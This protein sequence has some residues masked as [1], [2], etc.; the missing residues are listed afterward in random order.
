MRGET[1][2]LLGLREYFLGRLQEKLPDIIVNG[3]LENRLPNNL[4]I[5]FPGV[6]GGSLLLSLN[7]IGVYASSGS[8]CSAG[9]PDSSHVLK[10]I[11]VDTDHY[12]VIR[13]SMGL[14]T[15]KENLDYVLQHLPA[16]WKGLR[17]KAPP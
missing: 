8:A 6:D 2:R 4:S 3:S 11:G 7:N 15:R 12:G 14:Q 9:S 16:I 1:E 17:S 5:G 13:F 10:A